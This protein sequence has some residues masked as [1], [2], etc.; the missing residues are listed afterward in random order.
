MPIYSDPATNA[1]L[2]GFATSIGS[3]ATLTIYNSTGFPLATFKLA[4]APAFVGNGML[5]LTGLPA[6]VT[7]SSVAPLGSVP[8]SAS[9]SD[10]SGNLLVSNLGVT[11]LTDSVVIVPSQLLPGQAVALLAGQIKTI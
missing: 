9:I 3:S 5:L 1:A 2:T 11:L 6:V 8:V 10:A 4:N 7:T